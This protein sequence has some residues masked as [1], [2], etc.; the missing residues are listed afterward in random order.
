MTA[1][2]SW[3]GSI[4]D[5]KQNE[6]EILGMK[7]LN[8]GN[9]EY[10]SANQFIVYDYNLYDSW[11]VNDDETKAAYFEENYSDQL[12]AS[13]EANPDD[14]FNDEYYSAMYATADELF[15]EADASFE[16]ASQWD[17]RGDDL[18]LAMLLMALGLAFAA[19]GSLLKEESNLR[20]LFALASFIVLVVGV[21]NYLTVPVVG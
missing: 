7:K 20:I 8:D 2:V 13:I 17:N 11:Y 21:L 14:P 19:W 10:L 6:N 18:Q 15:N 4:A 9:A 3:Q 1:L 5:S 16:T 12:V